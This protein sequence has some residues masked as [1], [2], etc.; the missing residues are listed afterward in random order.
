MLFTTITDMGLGRIHYSHLNMKY[1][2][3]NKRGFC[4]LCIFLHLYIPNKMIFT[5]IAAVT[6]R[7]SEFHNHWYRISTKETLLNNFLNTSYSSETDAK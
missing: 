1:L 7:Q 3:I 5:H 6:I 4:T 2:T